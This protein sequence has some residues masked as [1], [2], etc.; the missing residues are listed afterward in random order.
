MSHQVNLHD[1]LGCL[2]A[3]SFLIDG[4]FSLSVTW[5]CMGF[6]ICQRQFLPFAHL[7]VIFDNTYAV[8]WLSV[9]WLACFSSCID[10]A[11]DWLNVQLYNKGSLQELAAEL[12]DLD[13]FAR[14]LKVNDKR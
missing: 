6:Y 7:G 3:G 5:T 11:M 2:V 1:H 14:V 13:V 10:I 12:S 8:K 9:V 4:I